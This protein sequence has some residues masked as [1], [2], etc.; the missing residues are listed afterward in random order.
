MNRVLIVDDHPV[1]RMAVRMLLEQAGFEIVAEA[2]NGID[3]LHQTRELQPDIVILD[4]GIPKLDGLDLIGR[5]KES[6]STSQVLVLTSQDPEYLSVRCMQAGAA[7]FVSKNQDLKDILNAINA[8]KSGYMYFPNQL[9]RTVRANADMDDEPG[10]ISRLTNRELMV[11]KQ[12]AS[13]MSNKQI[14]DNMALSNK[15]I[16]TYKARLHLKL[17]TSSLVE[18]IELA[19]RNA[20]V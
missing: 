12:L 6:G 8:I 10:R 15:T 2:D 9:L 17:K 13:G 20:L 3:G 14:G 4:I 11:L 7:G 18:L 1:I 5:I 19:K 16:S